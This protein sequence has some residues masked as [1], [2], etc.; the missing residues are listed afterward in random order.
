MNSLKQKKIIAPIIGIIITLLLFSCSSINRSI[1]ES[2]RKTE[3]KEKIAALPICPK[4][5]YPID[6]LEIIPTDFKVDFKSIYIFHAG[7]GLGMVRTDEN[8]EITFEPTPKKLKDVFDPSIQLLRTKGYSVNLAPKTDTDSVYKYVECRHCGGLK[9]ETKKNYYIEQKEAEDECLFT[10][11]DYTGFFRRLVNKYPEAK[12]YQITALISIYLDSG[13]IKPRMFLFDNRKQTLI[14]ESLVKEEE[15]RDKHTAPGSYRFSSPP[16][17]KGEGRVA[18]VNR[19]LDKM[20]DI[21]PNISGKSLPKK[22]KPRV[23]KA[24]SYQYYIGNRAP[25]TTEIKAYNTPPKYWTFT[26]PKN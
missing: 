24:Y 1:N 9:V 16:A 18:T 8:N 14:L 5:S 21:F 17:A 6:K 7:A 19:A 10:G 13:A 22:D 23:R 4:E 25:T 12:Q 15:L 20:L 2:I 3:A 11:L 26:Y